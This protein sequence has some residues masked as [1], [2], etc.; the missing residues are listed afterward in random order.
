MRTLLLVFEEVP[1]AAETVS[2]II[3]AGIVPSA[4]EMIDREQVIAV[5]NFVHAGFPTDAAAVLLGEV[6][7]LEDGVAA[8]AEL[9]ASK[10]K[11]AG[12]R[13]VRIAATEEERAAWWLGRKSAF[14]AVA[15]AAP[16]YYL[17]DTVVPRT[18][19]V[20]VMRQVYDIVSGVR[21]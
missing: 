11:A 7:G 12:A 20:D 8:E 19:L 16:D 6:A 14:G 13:E 18:R 15:H 10:A 5:E 21:A 2:R 17:H 9:I 3:A 1:A 4:L